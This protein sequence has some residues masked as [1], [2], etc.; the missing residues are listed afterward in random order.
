MERMSASHRASVG[1]PP[2]LKNYV[3]KLLEETENRVEDIKTAISQV[4]IVDVVVQF[5]EEAEPTVPDAL[6]RQKY[7]ELAQVLR[8]ELRLRTSNGVSIQHQDGV[9]CLNSNNNTFNY[10]RNAPRVEGVGDG[11]QET[12]EYGKLSGE[13]R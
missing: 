12:P 5:L 3:R 2:E 8:S 4:L 13:V 11:S 9:F 7:S 6:L 10:G 1:L